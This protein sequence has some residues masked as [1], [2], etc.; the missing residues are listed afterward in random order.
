MPLL[1]FIAGLLVHVIVILVF[2]LIEK[3]IHLIAPSVTPLM[4]F[5]CAAK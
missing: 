1:L 2:P 5:F 3:Q 4:I